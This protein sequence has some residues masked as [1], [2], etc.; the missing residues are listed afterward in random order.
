MDR[1]RVKF[2]LA[3]RKNFTK[4]PPN[5]GALM[6]EVIRDALI[7]IMSWVLDRR[8][9]GSEAFRLLFLIAFSIAA[10][11][12]TFYWKDLAYR[13]RFL[14][15]RLMPEERYVGRYLQAVWRQGELRY[16]FVHIYYNWRRHRF[17][18]AGRSYTTA[19]EEAGAFKS[20]YVLFPSDKDANIEFIWQASNGSTG[21]TRMIIE[22][23]DEDYIQGDGHIMTFAAKPE[24]YP[25]QF[26]H[27]HEGHVREALGVEC[28]CDSSQ[29]PPFLKKFHG[30][31]GARVADG[32]APPS[33][34]VEA[35]L[36]PSS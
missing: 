12:L 3:P 2:A 34:A 32:F 13:S 14:R 29:E 31:Y 16:S 17:E 5:R 19:G 21:Y 23:G 22:D 30:I 8:P 15:R 27:L 6:F 35:E 10:T 9:H 25:I 18:V 28:P 1:A 20:S 33:K 26:K 7:W 11:V 36:A 24:A 4:I